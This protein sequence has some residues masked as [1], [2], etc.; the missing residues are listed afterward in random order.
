[1]NIVDAGD[2]SGNPNGTDQ[3]DRV[4]VDKLLNSEVGFLAVPALPFGVLVQGGL[5]GAG[6]DVAAGG[7]GEQR[8]ALCSNHR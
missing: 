3:P 5:R 4:G 2:P 1:M 7:R 8:G 6:Q